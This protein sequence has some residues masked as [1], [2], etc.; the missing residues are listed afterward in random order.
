MAHPQRQ[1][2]HHGMKPLPDYQTQ[3][4]DSYGEYLTEVVGVDAGQVMVGDPTGE[5]YWNYPVLAAM[6]IADF[7]FAFI[8]VVDDSDNYLP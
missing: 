5:R 3:M 2:E 8:G 6:L 7:R 4:L 1:L